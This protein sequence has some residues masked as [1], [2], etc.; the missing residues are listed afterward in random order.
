M[1]VL[2]VAIICIKL[3]VAARERCTLICIHL[4]CVLFRVAIFVVVELVVLL[5]ISVL[6]YFSNTPNRLGHFLSREECAVSICLFG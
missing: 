3:A 1:S 2:S 5:V 4:I 6:L